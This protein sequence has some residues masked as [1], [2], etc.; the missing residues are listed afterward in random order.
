MEL[1]RLRRVKISVTSRRV[2]TSVTNFATDTSVPNESKLH[3]LLVER[4]TPSQSFLTDLP[5]GLQRH[6]DSDS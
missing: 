3:F 2:K 4:A 6:L 1:A 5:L